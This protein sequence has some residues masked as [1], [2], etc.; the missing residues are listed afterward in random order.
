MGGIGPKIL[1]FPKFSDMKQIAKFLCF[2]KNLPFGKLRKRLGYWPQNPKFS[3]VFLYVKFLCFPKYSQ[4]E[5]I[6]NCWKFT[7]WKTQEKIGGIG[8]N[9]KQSA[10]VLCSPKYS[11]LENIG[12]CWKQFGGSQEFLGIPIIQYMHI[13]LRIPMF[14]Q[15]FT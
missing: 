10:K 6:G 14:S 11:Q 9:R 13:K 3:K 12:N 8:P 5:N 2:P 15:Y 4:L 1:S 7:F